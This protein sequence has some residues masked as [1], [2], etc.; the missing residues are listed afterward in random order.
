MSKTVK[1]VIVGIVAGVALVAGGTYAYNEYNDLRE[2]KIALTKDLKETQEQKEQEAAKR[3]EIENDLNETKAALDKAEKDKDS[4]KKEVSN[5]KDKIAS[6]EEELSFKIAAREEAERQAAV[7]EASKAEEQATYIETASIS[8][9]K[10]YNIE[11]QTPVQSETQAQ[12]QPEPAPSYN[13]SGGGLTASAGVYNGPSGKETYYSQKVLPGGGL[14][15]PGRH[16]E[17]DGTV[18]DA[19]GYIVIASDNLSKGS[20][21]ETSLGT[22]KVYDTGVGHA[23]VDIYTNW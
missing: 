15:I 4:S 20:V 1:R 2:D 6:L 17:A 12:A 11:N 14:N 10:A 8:E 7:A 18:R 9:N 19:D 3:T 21:A 22:G 5:L 23:G 13:S 16:V